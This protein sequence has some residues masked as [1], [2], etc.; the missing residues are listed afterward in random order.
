MLLDK[1]FWFISE[2]L[3]CFTGR[4]KRKGQV[5]RVLVLQEKIL[6]STR[7]CPTT[8]E[9]EKLYWK[10]DETRKCEINTQVQI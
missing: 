9:K 7:K 6:K 2:K 3:P 8:S 10:G 1:P 5:G 4:G